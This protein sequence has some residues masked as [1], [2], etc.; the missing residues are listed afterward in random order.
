MQDV[1]VREIWT[2][3]FQTSQ[4]II[5][6]LCLGTWMVLSLPVTQVWLVCIIGASPLPNHEHAQRITMA[7]IDEG[8]TRFR[9]PNSAW[10]PA[11]LALKNNSAAF[12]YFVWQA[13]DLPKGWIRGKMKGIRTWALWVST[14]FGLNPLHPGSVGKSIKLMGLSF[15]CVCVCVVVGGGRGCARVCACPVNDNLTHSHTHTLTHM[16]L[17]FSLV[18][19]LFGPRKSSKRTADS[20]TQ[21]RWQKFGSSHKLLTWRWR[22][23]FRT[24]RLKA[25][26]PWEMIAAQHAQG[27]ARG[28]NAWTCKSWRI[29]HTSPE[30][31]KSRLLRNLTDTPNPHQAHPAYAHQ[32]HRTP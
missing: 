11:P 17:H 32:G 24:A 6:G 4:K 20:L 28:W 10:N 29:H 31:H 30:K 8:P 15:V 5:I 14:W 9:G 1:L 2:R 25:T 7:T 19:L 16:K 12:V 18:L 3:K 27:L 23:K 26:G 21:L 13:L 22:H